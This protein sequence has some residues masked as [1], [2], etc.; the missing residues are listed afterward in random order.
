MDGLGL[1][2]KE[3]PEMTFHYGNHYPHPFGK[4]FTTTFGLSAEEFFNFS[5][6]ADMI[7]LSHGKYG[8]DT[9]LIDDLQAWGKTVYV[10]GSEIGKNKWRDLDLQ[11]QV[12]RGEFTERGA[13]DREMQK[14]VRAYFRREKPYLPGMIPFPLG[15][16]SRFM[17]YYDSSKPKDIDF[18]CIFGQD[19]YPVTRRYATELTEKF[20]KENSFVCHT[21]K[22]F[23]LPLIE[24]GPY[25]P[26]KSYEI[27]ARTKVGVSTG[28]AGYDS[29]R[30]WEILGNNCLVIAERFDL[31][32]PDSDMMNFKRIFQYN[33]LYDFEYQ[34]KKV[35]EFLR[36][37]Y[38]QK[39]LDAEYQEIL[40]LHSTKARAMTIITE[41][42]R[43]GL[44]I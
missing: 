2:A 4:D 32:E 35:G 27:W 41:A 36:S 42:R 18:A 28:A 31:Y 11:M 44:L 22:T 25:S 29:R 20:C 13:P 7:I 38:N 19:L 16:E 3:H 26:D 6:T 37:G 40:K 12:I 34:L 23:K 8:T 1:L 9:G 30:F 14:K 33:N 17:K 24:R 15:I 39:D 10:D 5:K 43:I 21:K